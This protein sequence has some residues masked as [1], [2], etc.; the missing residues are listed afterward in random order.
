MQQ[1]FIWII[2][3]NM[4]NFHLFSNCFHMKSTKITTHEHTYHP[5][6]TLETIQCN[7]YARHIF[8][9][10]STTDSQ[11]ILLQVL[12]FY[13]WN[14]W[15]LDPICSTVFFISARQQQFLNFK[16]YIYSSP[17]YIITENVQNTKLI[18][19]NNVILL[20]YETALMAWYHLQK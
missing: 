7:E 10:L 8:L 12:K 1:Y 3:I 9:I 18:K 11:Q 17:L 6:V 19:H 5:T 16:T 15:F 14:L 4:T 20:E 13:H 2:C